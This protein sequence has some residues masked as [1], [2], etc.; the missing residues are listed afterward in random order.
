MWRS[1]ALAFIFVF[2][3]MANVFA[4]C[5]FTYVNNSN[6]PVTLQ[7]FF[8]SGGESQND[9]MWVT[10][11]AGSK[12]KQLRIGG[13]C[14]AVYLHTGQMVTRVNLKNN[15]GYWLGNK[16]FLFV[17]D[18]SYSTY[19][20]NRALADDGAEI[21]LSNGVEVTSRQ[22]KVFICD[23]TVNSDDCN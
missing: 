15:S 7:G 5:Q 16:G 13:K 3:G 1:L 18:R 12:A 6:H 4:D 8:L 22:F 17:D 19:K 14:D 11:K 10:L 2:F 9:L 21:S 23:G 20:A